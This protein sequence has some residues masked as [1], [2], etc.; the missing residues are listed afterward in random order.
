L[1]IVAVPVLAQ[2]GPSLRQD[3]E[4]LQHFW[5]AICLRASNLDDSIRAGEQ[6]VK[7]YAQAPYSCPS[8]APQ[9]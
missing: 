8:R 6:P 9:L 3:T 2:T 7:N 4:K 1:I 5:A